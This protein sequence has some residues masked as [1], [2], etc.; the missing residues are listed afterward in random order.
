MW[1][2]SVPEDAVIDRS[3]GGG[4]EVDPADATTIAWEEAFVNTALEASSD[5]MLVTPNAVKSFSDV[6]SQAVFFDI[7]LM[8]IGYT[9]MFLYTVVMLGRVSLLD[10]RFYLSIAG[11]LSVFKGLA[12]SVSVASL[13]GFPYTPMHAALPFL[14]LGTLPYTVASNQ[15][16]FYVSVFDFL[17]KFTSPALSCFVKVTFRYCLDI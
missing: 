4:L 9:A 7:Y 12:I 15:N 1:T 8:L 17:V 13:L 2:L 5:T 3:L 11:I 10:V 14:C 16:P 6:S